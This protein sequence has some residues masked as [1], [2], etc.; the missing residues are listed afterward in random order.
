MV[1]KVTLSGVLLDPLNKPLPGVLIELKSVKT[2]NVISGLTAEFVTNQDGSYSVDVPVGSYKCAVIVKDRETSLPGYVNVYD[3][4]GAG[5]L[6]EYLYAPCQEDGEPMFIVQWEMIRQEI[7]ANRD[8]IAE[9]VSKIENISDGLENQFLAKTFFITESD[10]NGTIAGIEGTSN[11]EVFRVAQGYGKDILYIYYKNSNGTAV[12]VGDSASG[13][14]VQKISKLVKVSSSNNYFQRWMDKIGTVIA[15]WTSENDGSVGFVSKKLNFNKNGFF[16]ESA[17]FSDE[18]IFNKNFTIKKSPDGSYRIID[19]RGVVYAVINDDGLKLSSININAIN[20]LSL[21]S[22][23]NKLSFNGKSSKIRVKDKRGITG[24]MIDS[25][26]LVHGKMHDEKESSSYVLTENDI[27]ER[28]ESFS[29]AKGSNRFNSINNLSP[30]T[31]KKIKVILGYG[32]SF[33]AGAQGNA[34][35]SDEPTFN[36]M[37][38]GMSPRGSNFSNPTVYTFGPVGGENKF[39]PMK[40]VFQDTSGNII[41]SG[42]YGETMCSSICH[43]F[44][45]LHNESIGVEDD[46]NVIV[47]MGA[48]GVSG[49]SISQLQK[50]ADPELYNRVETFLDGV[51]EAAAA[52]GYEWEVI[53]I[54]YTQG[55]NDNGSSYTSYLNALKTMKGNLEK[56]CMDKSGQKFT[57]VFVLNQIGNT[58]INGMGVPNAQAAIADMYKNVVMVGSYQGMMNPGAHLVSNSYRLLGSI[59]GKEIYRYYAGNG[60]YPFKMVKCYYTKDTVYVGTTPKVPPLSFKSVFN[61]YDETMYDDKGFSVTDSQGT[62]SGSDLIVSIISDRV[63]KIKA[64]RVLTGSVTVS[65]GD[66]SHAGIHNLCDSSLEQSGLDWIYGKPGQYT[67]ENNANLVDKPYQLTNF[68]A[69][70]SITSQEL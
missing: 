34:V 59:I 60:D 52:M 70:G 12:A 28:I 61:K 69:I 46:E 8:F 37:M 67:Q 4:S 7:S 53:A 30:K 24:F 16:G 58:C 5:T 31:R 44:K 1:G 2:G 27:V 62:L 57:P 32:Q 50:G 51:A 42:G 66:K 14:L 33:D 65:I 56:S 21:L 40:E 6:N 68:C 19:S 29:F 64:S 45:R 49:R 47:V 54:K 38:L 18:I 13:T 25:Y 3:Y 43:E 9:S 20:G 23:N 39:Y 26:G 11:G 17:V 10:P 36:S 22:G 41:T 48:C 55:E 15:G 63:V 35:L